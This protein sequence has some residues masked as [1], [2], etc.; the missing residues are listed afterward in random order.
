MK[1][2]EKIRLKKDYNGLIVGTVYEIGNITND[3]YVIR[4]EVNKVAI[5]TIPIDDLLIYFEPINIGSWT[6]W[7]EFKI[8]NV[9]YN[10]LFLYRTNGKKFQVK[11]IL[12]KNKYIGEASCNP[13][14]EFDFKT[15]LTLATIRCILKCKKEEIR[16]LNIFIDEY[17]EV[18]ESII[19]SI[20]MKILAI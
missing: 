6:S 3:Y 12:N 11:K 19:K 15:G 13:I 17:K 18:E 2:G 7:K 20:K 5:A 8:D 9:G 1:N 10:D 16:Q 14:D 4:N